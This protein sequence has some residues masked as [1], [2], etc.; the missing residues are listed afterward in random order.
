MNSQIPS[1]KGHTFKSKQHVTLQRSLKG[2]FFDK[3]ERAKNGKS[4]IDNIRTS[5]NEK[6]TDYYGLKTEN[7]ELLTFNKGLQVESNL[8]IK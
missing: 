7:R 8:V 2:N 4:Y 6:E 5:V 1:F 3:E